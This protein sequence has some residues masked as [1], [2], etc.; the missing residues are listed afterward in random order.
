MY[1]Y[2]HEDNM[3]GWGAAG[4]NRFSFRFANVKRILQSAL[5][6]DNEYIQHPQRQ[7][8]LEKSVELLDHVTRVDRSHRC[9][10]R[11]DTSLSA[12]VGAVESRRLL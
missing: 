7:F 3:D 6:S 5:A 11:R 9:R 4:H 10:R 2:L 8:F 1:L 12:S